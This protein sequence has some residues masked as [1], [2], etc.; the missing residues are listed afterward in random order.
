MGKLRHPLRALVPEDLK[1]CLDLVLERR[2]QAGVS[3]NNPYFFGT[4][5]LV[6]G[7]YNYL[8]ASSVLSNIAHKSNVEHPERLKATELRKH[9]ATYASQMQLTDDQIAEAARFMGHSV[10]IHN[11][12]YVQ[13]SS[14]WDIVHM[15]KVLEAA[16]GENDESKQAKSTK[17]R[18]ASQIPISRDVDDFGHEITETLDQVGKSK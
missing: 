12:I 18:A 8:R 17:N 2:V 14:V 5:N 13:H 15:S 16:L 6:A 11:N 4:P 1:E 3:P 7:Q 10:R 9:M